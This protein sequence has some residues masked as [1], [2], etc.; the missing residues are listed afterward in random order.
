VRYEEVGCE[1]WSVTLREEDGLR[2]FENRVLRGVFG[3]K[4]KEVTG[5]WRRLHNEELY[6]LYCSLNTIRV[7]NSRRM[8]LERHVARMGRREMPGVLTGKPEGKTLYGR[9]T[10][11]WEDNIE[12]DLREI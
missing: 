2:V 4:G 10:H 1:T 11:R 8:R 12:M 7:I 3:F 6:G 9:P 5:D